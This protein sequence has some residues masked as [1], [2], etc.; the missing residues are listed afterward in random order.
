VNLSHSSAEAVYRGVANVVAETAWIRNLLRELHTP[1]FTA[2]LVYC[3]NVSV[4]YMYANPVQHQRTKHIEINIHF[5]RDYVAFGQVR[6]LHIPSWFQYAD[7]FTKG[8][9]S[10]LFLEFRFSINVRRPPVLTAEE[11]HANLLCIVP[12]LSD[13]GHAQDTITV[14]QAIRDG[15]TLVSAD[16]MFELGSLLVI[17]GGNNIVVWS[18]NTNIVPPTSINPV[19]QILNTGNLV[20]RG[21]NEESFI[22]QSFDY[23]GDTYLAGMK[24][25]KDLVSGIDRRCTPWKSID[26]PSPGEYVAFID[27]NGFPQ[28]REENGSVPMMRLGPWNGITFN[29][30][31]NHGRNSILTHGFVFNDKEVFYRYALVNSSAVVSRVIV[32]PEG[33]FS[34]M[35]WHYKKKRL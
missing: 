19:A 21:N 20:V 11:G 14:N 24:F 6:V 4:V 26:D 10:A 18:S 2:T 12:I 35:N 22:W 27:T 23:P 1:L 3:D 25:G 15:D 8:L 13:G 29:S 17:A 28:L 30:L 5:V 34:R 33:D 31:P 7:I 9:P 32:S 16:E